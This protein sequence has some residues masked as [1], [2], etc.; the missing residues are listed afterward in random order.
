MTDTPIACELSHEDL[1]HRRHTL[2]PGLVEQA[3]EGQDLADGFRWRF[4][5]EP[6]LLSRIAAVIDAEGRCCRFMRFRVEVEAADGPVWL[7][8]TGPEGTVPFLSRLIATEPDPV[9]RRLAD[10]RATRED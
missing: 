10:P 4:E 8:V 6:D 2:L 3:V 9:R 7:E 5:P 1:K